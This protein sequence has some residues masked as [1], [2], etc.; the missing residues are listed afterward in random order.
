MN[1][2]FSLQNSRL[3]RAAALLGL[4]AGLAGCLLTNRPT[5][6]IIPN[7]PQT[8]IPQTPTPPPDLRA[9]LEDAAQV[10]AGVCFEAAYDARGRAFVLTSPIDHINFYDQV[11]ASRLCRWPV[12]RR[13]FDFAGGRALVGVWS[14]GRG[15][16]ASH[17]IVEAVRDPEAMTIRIVAR[18]STQGECSYELIRPLWLAV[19]GA[20]GY[21]ITLEVMG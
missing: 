10:M 5:M 19:P 12:E 18:F 21:R 1:K 17:E 13:P 20:E 11:D 9:S 7:P 4:A 6:T 16:T 2:G 3:W 14:Y 8:V 15:C